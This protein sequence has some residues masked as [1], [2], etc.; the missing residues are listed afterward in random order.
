MQRWMV[1]ATTAIVA[2]VVL[3][4]TWGLYAVILAV[5]GLRHPPPQDDITPIGRGR[6]LW[7][8]AALILLIL[9]FSPRPLP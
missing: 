8:A 6:W 1:R 9:T 3:S 4:P 2:L 7:A 5:V